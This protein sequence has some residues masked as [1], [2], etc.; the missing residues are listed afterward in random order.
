MSTDADFFPVKR[1]KL[2]FLTGLQK[3]HEDS[4]NNFPLLQMETSIVLLPFLL[5]H[6][7]QPLKI[8]PLL[9]PAY[10][11]QIFLEIAISKLLD[12]WCIF[13]TTLQ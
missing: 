11:Q 2:F 3:T 12:W 10:K 6:S 9:V 4:H 1:C 8:Q 5:P 13:I 7:S